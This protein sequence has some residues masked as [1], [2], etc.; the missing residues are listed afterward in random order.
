[1]GI[2]S[3][4]SQEV[5]DRFAPGYDAEELQYIY[6]RA[7]VCERMGWR[8]CD[9]DEADVSDIHALIAVFEAQDKAV[10]HGRHGYHR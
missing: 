1:M 4:F 10:K 5:L 6:T 8:L 3:G 9:F 7:V 2:K